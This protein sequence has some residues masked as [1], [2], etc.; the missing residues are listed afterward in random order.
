V[1]GPVTDVRTGGEK[2]Y[3]PPKKCP[4]CSQPVEHLEGEVA[5]YCVNA[6]CPAQL[7]RN[8]EHF[9]SRGSMDMVGLGTKIVEKL[10]ETGAV[11]DAADI[12][13]LKRADILEAVT[14][15]DRKTE[16]EPP[17]K[18]A[19]NLLTSIENSRR[20]PLSRLLT[21]LGIRGVGE[22]VAGDLA[23]HFGDLDSL[24]KAGV[25]DLMEIEGVG[26]NIAEAIVDWFERPANQKVLAKLKKAG[27]WPK[28]EATG[29]KKEGK[30]SGMTFVITGTL[31]NFSREQAKE[32]IE[33]QGGKV[34]DSVSKK[35]SYLVL[36]EEPGSKFE[37]AQSL[38]VKIINEQELKKLGKA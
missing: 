24:S 12:Y 14:K 10:I 29:K 19:D 22:V 23:R 38:G 28:A 4:V 8:V 1:I 5:W 36:G 16:K 2:K 9:V 30:F 20:Q 26:P 27:V 13:S 18:I 34:T 3:V 32:F 31:P 11:K 25:D 35:T 33:E 21:A 37:K 6:A 7:M 15:K 17:G